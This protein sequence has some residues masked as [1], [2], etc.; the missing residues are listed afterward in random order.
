MFEHRNKILIIATIGWGLVQATQFVLPPMLPNIIEDL[1]ITVFQAGVAMTLLN[2]AY[3]L[4][5]YPGGKFSD[6]LT[7]VTL[8]VPGMVM[9][10]LGLIF[11]G[12]RPTYAA[13]LAG[14][15]I[16]GFGRSTFSIPTRARIADLFG[17]KKGRALGILFI[18]TELGG[19]IGAGL[20]FMV[21]VILMI[22][23]RFA[24][25][26]LFIGLILVGIA[27][28]SWSKEKYVIKKVSLDIGDTARRIFGNKRLFLLIMSYSMLWFATLS[29]LMFLPLY[30][31]YAKGFSPELATI[32]FSFLFAVG[33]IIKPV[34]GEISDKFERPKVA[35]GGLLLS[36]F[37]MIWLVIAPTPVY[38]MIAVIAFSI[39]YKAQPPVIESL[40]LDMIDDK[41]RGGDLGAAKTTATGIGALGPAYIGFVAEKFSYDIAF[42]GLVI[43][44]GI[45][46]AIIAYVAYGKGHDN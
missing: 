35:L 2:I 16:L 41:N 4:G 18:G 32:V 20:A 14:V 3:A 22:S 29:V 19:L 37:A 27:Y 40:M 31:Q 38:I 12:V 36:V 30:L 43:V 34:A 39:G 9:T 21:I 23:W 7:R 1:S 46:A 15:I 13:F 6:Q 8:I 45:S 42:F 11:I 44:L 5:M 10:I 25:V 17:E 24:L 28:N 26:P 33:I